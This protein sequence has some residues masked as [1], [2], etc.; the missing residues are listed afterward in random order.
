MNAKERKALIPQGIRIPDAATEARAWTRAGGKNDV[1][2]VLVAMVSETWRE[3]LHHN[4]EIYLV[5]H[6][7]SSTFPHNFPHRRRTIRTIYNLPV[8]FPKCG[9]CTRDYVHSLCHIC[10]REIVIHKTIIQRNKKNAR[11]EK[12]SSRVNFFIFIEP[13]SRFE[14]LTYS[15]PWNC[16]TNW[17]TRAYGNKKSDIILTLYRKPHFKT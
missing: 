2:D 3:K 13:A 1:E 4:P 6:I 8:Y 7:P 15:L 5:G 9:Y 16:S 12:L 17:A 14:L 11:G 10:L